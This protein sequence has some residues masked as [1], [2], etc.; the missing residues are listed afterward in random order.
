MLGILVGL[1][2]EA[3]L[4][5]R[6]FPDAVIALSHACESGAVRALA[7]LKA[8][9]AT[10]LLSFGCAGGLD[11]DLPPGTVQVADFV[12]VDGQS[13]LTDEVLSERFG[14][15]KVSVRGGLY[16]SNVMIAQAV[17]KAALFHQTKCHAVDMESGI[18][19]RSGLPFAV[20]R[21][22]CDDAARNLPPAAA[23]ALKEGKVHIPALLVSL[24]QHPGQIGAL[25]TLGRD[26][27]QAHK[28]MAEFLKQL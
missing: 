5:K 23:V 15:N 6:F 8:A 10:E 4:A 28:S 25:M 2:Q 13:I 26:A 16:H 17:E 20:L 22:V 18:V 3:Q 7:E 21:V 14:A 24:V 12:H 1:K 11:E 27:A 19:A 9:G